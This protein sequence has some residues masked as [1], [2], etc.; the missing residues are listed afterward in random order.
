V[1]DVRIAV[2]DEDGNGEISVNSPG[3]MTGMLGGEAPPFT[4]NG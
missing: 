2:P 3:L 4:E 1:I